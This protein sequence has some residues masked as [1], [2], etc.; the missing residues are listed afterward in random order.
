MERKHFVLAKKTNYTPNCELGAPK[1]QLKIT[2]LN[3]ARKSEEPVDSLCI[4]S[5][6]L[7]SHVNTVTAW[8]NLRLLCTAASGHRRSIHSRVCMPLQVIP[9]PSG[10]LER[11]DNPMPSSDCSPQSW[12][13]RWQQKKRTR[14]PFRY[15]V[16]Q[17]TSMAHN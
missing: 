15:C 10:M 14:T 16:F 8:G 13:S 12:S 1:L 17:L 6:S 4:L 3:G 5:T 9:G 11:P 7:K 2:K